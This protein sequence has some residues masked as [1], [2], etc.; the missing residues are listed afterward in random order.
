VAVGFW[1][2]VGAGLLGFTINPPASLY[3][4]QGLN[5]TPAHGHAALFGV[6]GM[7]GIGLTLFCLRG[8]FDRLVHADRLLAWSFWSLNIGLAMMVF[9]SLV[10]AGIY[11]ASA[12]ISK[13][14]WYARSPEIVHSSVMETLVWLRVPGDI[15]FA[16]GGICLGVY[17]VRLLAKGR[18]TAVRARTVPV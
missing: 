12:A 9:M 1:K 15:V 14:L 8:L 16:A 7:L 10:P 2:T 11:Q 13:G 6:Y 5:M 17:A 18:R 4:V 3:Y